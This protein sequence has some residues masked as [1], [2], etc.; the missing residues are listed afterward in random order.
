LNCLLLLPSPPQ[1]LED[2]FIPERATYQ[3][4]TAG[5]P[6]EPLAGLVQLGGE[7]MVAAGI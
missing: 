6:A 7:V 2:I 3:P 5:W 4:N 1:V